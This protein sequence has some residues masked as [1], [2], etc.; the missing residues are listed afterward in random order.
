MAM[1]QNNLKTTLLTTAILSAIGIGTAGCG[2]DG[3]SDKDFF[4]TGDRQVTK[5][6]NA[7]ASAGARSDATLSAAHFDGGAL[8]SLGQQKLDLITSE[9]PDEGPVTI[10]L[11]LPAD[12]A[13]AQARKDAVTAYLIDSHLTAEQF[14]L[15]D[16]PNDGT[17]T[18]AATA[19]TNMSKTETD[20]SGASGSGSSSSSGAASGATGH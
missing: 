9:L 6:E 11:D 1:I 15:K 8:N 10:Y 4:P 18:P 14:K 17:W 13:Q 19:L 2:A 7:Q 5:I 12:G 16:G 20:N 3:S